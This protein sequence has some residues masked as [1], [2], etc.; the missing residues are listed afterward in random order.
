[1]CTIVQLTG[2]GDV[3]M[4][5]ALGPARF[6]QFVILQRLTKIQEPLSAVTEHSSKR[7]GFY[8]TTLE[9]GDL[10]PF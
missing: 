6:K 10:I 7:W 5:G 4:H 2:F 8:L 9:L 3:K 1:V